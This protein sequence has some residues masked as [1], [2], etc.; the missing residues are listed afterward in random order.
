MTLSR[1]SFSA[2]LAAAFLL[3][4][5][6]AAQI[7]FDSFDR[8]ELGLP[9]PFNGEGVGIGIGPT[10]G[11]GGA[12]NTA[13]S[14]GI[15]PGNG[16][17]AG[18]TVPARSGNV[19]VSDQEFLTFY[20]RA[21]SN[22]NPIQA[23]N[24]PITLEINLQ[25]DSNGD[26]MYTATAEDEYQAVYDVMIGTDYQYVEIPL[27]AFA[28]DNSVNG[29]NNDGFDFE[30]LR[31]VVFAIGGLKGPE[32]AFAIDEIVF[33]DESRFD[34][35]EELAI[36]D[37]FDRAELGLPE[38]F[39]G[40]GVGIGIGPTTGLGGAEN[41]ALSVGINPGNGGF[42][43]FTVPARS[44]NVDISD[45]EYF[46][47][48]L[49]ATSNGNPIQAANLPITLEINLQEDSNGDGMYTATAED[50]YQA[51]YDVMLGSDYTTIAI[52]L[53]A[54][55]DDNSVNGG[56]N[57]GF[58]FENLRQVVFAI[59]GLKGPE[60]AF[61]FD[62]IGFADADF[63]TSNE[64]PPSLA[65][66]PSVFPNP[67]VG[68][69]TVAFELASASEVSVD[70]VDLLG[71]RVAQLA[72]STRAAGPVRMELPTGALAAGLY[73]VRVRTADGVAATRLVVTR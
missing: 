56:N 73:V 69:A 28:D 63:I 41:T 7:T 62:E 9:E 15:N 29:G 17:F 48:S 42:A 34:V 50:E 37:S 72:P 6:A 22:G 13:L 27:Y 38:P 68:R 18:F 31:Q 39:N 47:F 40:E 59:G 43:G 21:T 12:E 55:A 66:A 53:Y 8:A 60:F 5:S 10:T 67:T 2:A 46:V 16:G 23:A 32:F 14:V 25:E 19:D 65:A 4:P 61:A 30:N 35:A 57:D 33:T 1:L 24:L 64:L 45:A 54:F 3:A 71:R 49:R 20:F 58:D 52:P 36:F 70:V 44:G 51:V 26:G 11:L